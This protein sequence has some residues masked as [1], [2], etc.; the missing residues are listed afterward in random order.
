[1]LDRLKDRLP[2]HTRQQRLAL[3]RFAFSEVRLRC[4]LNGTK[5]DDYG[6]PLPPSPSEQ[7]FNEVADVL[8]D[9]VANVLDD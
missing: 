5:L 1:M 9:H 6:K 8:F 4:A 2:E 7:A 3:L